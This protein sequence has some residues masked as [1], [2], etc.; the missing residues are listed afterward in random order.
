MWPKKT[1]LILP[2][3]WPL[4]DLTTQNLGFVGLPLYLLPC[5][6]VLEVLGGWCEKFGAGSRFGRG[7][8]PRKDC[9]RDAGPPPRH[10]LLQ[11]V[12]GTW[13]WKWKLSC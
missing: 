8:Y 4:L 5:K 1:V 3:N 11:Q 2:R 13:V 9:P 10:Q 6:Q 7:L 12:L